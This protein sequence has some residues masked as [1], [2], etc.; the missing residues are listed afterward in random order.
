VTGT[1]SPAVPTPLRWAATGAVIAGIVGGIVGLVL[2]LLAHPATAW[3]AVFELGIPASVL[4]GL[5]GLVAGAIAATVA[6]RRPAP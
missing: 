4:G 1:P 3:F 2:G 5:V 6:R